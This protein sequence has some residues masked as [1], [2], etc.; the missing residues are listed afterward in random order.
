MSAVTPVRVLS[1]FVR[2]IR[3]ADW[4][5][6]AECARRAV[7]R[8]PDGTPIRRLV[9]TTHVDPS[10]GKEVVSTRTVEVVDWAWVDATFMAEA[11]GRRGQSLRGELA[12][13]RVCAACP[14]REECLRWCL[15]L[16]AEMGPQVGIWGGLTPAERRQR[17][18]EVSAWSGIRTR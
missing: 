11:S 18:K 5:D 2:A 14:V 17:G 4:L 16:E 3:E 8:H 6:Q 7:V 1:S 10:T 13:K 9:R 15:E 12:A